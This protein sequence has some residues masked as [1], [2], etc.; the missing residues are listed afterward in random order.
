MKKGRDGGGGGGNGDERVKRKKREASSNG[1]GAVR[2]LGVWQ[3]AAQVDGGGLQQE[4]ESA[5]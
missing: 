5:C 1:S 4:G 2:V 3:S